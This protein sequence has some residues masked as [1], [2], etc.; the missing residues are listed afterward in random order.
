MTAG[1][2]LAR[3]AGA[4]AARGWAVL[5]LWWPAAGG[6]T[7]G[8]QECPSNGKHPL[9]DL[10]PHGLE[11]ATTDQSQ[12]V[13]WWTA[14]SSANVGLRTGAVS[15]LVVLDVDGPTGEASL[16]EL[17]QRHGR[18]RAAWARTGSGGWHAYLSHPG[19]EVPNS[20]SRL[21][22]KLDVRGDGGYVVA[23]PSLHASGDRYRWRS[24]PP[25]QLPPPPTWMLELLVP[26]PPP[27]ARPVRLESGLSAYV[28]AAVE[29]E[30]REVAQ[31]PAGQRNNR[32]NLAAYRLG[33]LVG[34][35]LVSEAGVSAV[36][37]AAAA[38]AGLAEHEARA[39]VRSGLTAGARHPR[40]VAS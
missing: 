16:R 31:A 19:Q 25:Q 37:L 32:L 36:L 40:D 1:R 21:G 27:P 3:S 39:T 2:S 9:G 14:R 8:R 10:V 13:R 11:Q 30:A 35:A 38:T 34:A 15:G 33:Q 17:A 29:G 28:V 24:A 4:Y 18:F 6:C 26:P 12:I 7:C 22:P 5:P 20:A 23:P